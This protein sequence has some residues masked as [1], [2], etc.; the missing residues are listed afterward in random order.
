MVLMLK[1]E[2]EFRLGSGLGLE[3][4]KESP[5]KYKDMCNHVTIVLN[6]ARMQVKRSKTAVS[7]CFSSCQWSRNIGE[8]KRDTL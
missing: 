8:D 1:R 5:H 4:H 3:R 2:L 7:E 6:V